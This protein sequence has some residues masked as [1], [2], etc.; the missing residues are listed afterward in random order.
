MYRPEI[1]RSGIGYDVHRLVHGRRCMLGGIEIPFDRGLDGH[2]DADV[3]LHA[4]ADAILGAGALGDIGRH[5]PPDEPQ[6]RGMDSRAIVRRSVELLAGVGMEPVHVDITVV[7]EAPKIN[8]HLERMQVAVGA[9]VGLPPETISI[10]ATTNERMGFIGREEGI[11]A[12]AVA[13]VA[14][15]AGSR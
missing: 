13:T 2:S 15:V 8:P 4:L 10:K 5:F 7:A 12:I 11:A 6:W 14:A 1:P 9:A 3:V